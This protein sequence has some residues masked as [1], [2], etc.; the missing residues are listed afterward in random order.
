MKLLKKPKR[1]ETKE[2]VGEG[3]RMVGYYHADDKNYK[4]AY[5]LL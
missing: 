3:L 2:E 4:K 1:L 5:E